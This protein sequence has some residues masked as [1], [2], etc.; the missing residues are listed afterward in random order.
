MLITYININPAWYTTAQAA[1]TTPVNENQV[2]IDQ[3]ADDIVNTAMSLIGQATYNHYEYKPTAPYEFGCSGFIYYVFLQNGIDMN[4]RN[5]QFQADLGEYVPKDQLQKGDLVFF[6]SSPDDAYPVTHDGI[7]IGDNKIIHMADSINNV[8]ISDL[9]SKAYYRDYY[10]MSRRLIPSYMPSANP[11]PGEEIVNVAESLIGKVQYGTYNENTLT[12]NNTGFDYYVYKKTGIDLGTQSLSQQANLGQYVPKDQLQKGDLVFFS[13]DS[14]NGEIRLVG[15]Y[16]G[17]NNVIINA[18][19]SIG[20][21]K[22]YM[23]T[24]FYENNYVTARRVISSSTPTV[25][26]GNKIATMAEGLIGKVNYGSSYNESTLTFNSAGFM[27]YIY[28][29]NEIDLKT[30]DASEQA[31]LGS[32]V[33]KEQLQIGDLVFFSRIPGSERISLVGIYSGNGNVIINAGTSTGVVER[34]LQ[35]DYYQKRYVTARRIQ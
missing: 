1:I 31:K 15:I 21:V 11:S 5:T 17:N 25:N 28:N 35:R 22:R 34:S 14:S 13:N 9:D 26:E 32:L 8:V 2:A 3:K 24:Y 29:K 10:K 23:S 18:S 30:K 6:D 7:Y 12:F 19:S 16:A 4:T 33:S 27:Y 20:V